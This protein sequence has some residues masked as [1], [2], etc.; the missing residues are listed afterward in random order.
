MVTLSC[1]DRIETANATPRRLTVYDVPLTQLLGPLVATLNTLHTGK[2]RI[3]TF[4]EARQRPTTAELSVPAEP[5]QLP[6]NR[7]V[8]HLLEK[9]GNCSLRPVTF[10][11]KLEWSSS[12]ILAGDDILDGSNT[13]Y[14]QVRTSDGYHVAQL[15]SYIGL[16]ITELETAAQRKA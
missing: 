4:N 8:R 13:A 6:T 3:S 16:L 14:V 10:E 2:G 1:C 5:Y 9:H 12:S 7:A 11:F 15:A